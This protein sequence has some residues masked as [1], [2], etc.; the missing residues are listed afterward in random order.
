MRPA[1]GGRAAGGVAGCLAGWELGWELG[2]P[3]NGEPGKK[4][5]SISANSNASDSDRSTPSE[6]LR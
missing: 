6:G 2:R 4:K 3:E 5:I 1:G